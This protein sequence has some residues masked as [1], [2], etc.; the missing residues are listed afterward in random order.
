MKTATIEDILD[1]QQIRRAIV[2]FDELGGHHQVVNR[3]VSEL[4]EPNLAEINKRLGQEN[5]ARYLAYAV[6]WAVSQAMKG[7]P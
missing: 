2:M 5:D 1:D 7:T 3:Y 4:I 6:Y